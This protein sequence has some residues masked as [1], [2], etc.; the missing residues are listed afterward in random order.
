MKKEIN[1]QRNSNN[2]N[3]FTAAAKI[4]KGET[5]RSEIRRYLVSLKL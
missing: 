5:S 1:I 2:N 4:D 3:N